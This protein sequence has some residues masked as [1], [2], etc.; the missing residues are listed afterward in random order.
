MSCTVQHEI[1]VGALIPLLKRQ[2][3]FHQTNILFKDYYPSVY[4]RFGIERHEMMIVMPAIM[5]VDLLVGCDK[6]KYLGE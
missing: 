4:E 5:T 3:D 2:L 1:P 6:L